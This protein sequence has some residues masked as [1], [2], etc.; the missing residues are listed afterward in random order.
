LLYILSG[1]GASG[2]AIAGVALVIGL[3]IGFEVGVLAAGRVIKD[4][5]QRGQAEAERLRRR[6]A[7]GG[8]GRH[9]PF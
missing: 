5:L 3:L 6:P 9:G 7:A 4:A 2:E 8:P 1:P